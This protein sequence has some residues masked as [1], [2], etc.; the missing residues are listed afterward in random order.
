ML[1]DRNKPD[2]CDRWYHIVF[3]ADS[4][5]GRLFDLVLLVLIALSMLVVMLYSVKSLHDN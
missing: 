2:W 1:K 5:Q 4:R 3:Y